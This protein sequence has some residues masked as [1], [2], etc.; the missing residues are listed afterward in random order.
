MPLVGLGTWKSKPGEVRLHNACVGAC[1]HRPLDACQLGVAHVTLYDHMH[2][3]A[4]TH[5]L[6]SCQ[7]AVGAHVQCCYLMVSFRRACLP[8][9]ERSTNDVCFS[10]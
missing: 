9:D 4:P 7:E 1:V 8:R 3:R 10:L 6:Y 5:Q 2:S